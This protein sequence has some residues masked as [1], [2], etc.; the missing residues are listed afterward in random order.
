MSTSKRVCCEIRCNTTVD[1]RISTRIPF[2]I[3]YFKFS[4]IVFETILLCWRSKQILRDDVLHNRCIHSTNQNDARKH[5]LRNESYFNSD[6]EVEITSLKWRG[7]FSDLMKKCYLTVPSI[8]QRRRKK[9]KRE[10]LILA[11]TLYLVSHTKD[12]GLQYGKLF[13]WNRLKHEP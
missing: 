8:C 10:T 7:H 4:Q 12:L 5:R 9:K 11:T 2:E 3:K 6:T 13:P 1:N